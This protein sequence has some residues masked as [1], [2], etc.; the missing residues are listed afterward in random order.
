V[1]GRTGSGKSTICLS[2][3][4]L[5]EAAA[6]RIEIDGVDISTLGLDQLREALSIIPQ[7]RID[8]V[9][10]DCYCTFMPCC[11]SAACQCVSPCHATARRCATHLSAAPRFAR[12]GAQVI[13]FLPAAFPQLPT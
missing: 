5:I 12:V 6:G 8:Y 1:V 13:P 11:Y 9:Q 4:R 7:V 10:A 3:F 2:L